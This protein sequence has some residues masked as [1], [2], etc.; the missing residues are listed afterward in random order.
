[1]LFADAASP[2]FSG[3]D[4]FL[5]TRGSF[6]LDF[7][8][9]AMFAVIPLLAVS[10][11]LVRYRRMYRVHK[12]MQV[13]LGVILLAAVTLFEVDMRIHGWR[14]RAAGSD[15]VVPAVVNWSLYVHL[16][17]AVSTAVL[18]VFVTVQALRKFPRPVRPSPYS[19]AHIFWARL[20]AIDM[21]LT[22]ITGWVFY[23]LAFVVERV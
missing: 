20:A 2:D 6:M 8:F 12:I 3:I 11:Y 15:G 13:T 1:M 4:G 23:Y 16:V 18:W 7:V 21:T 10:I 17:F 14:D 19:P 9:V 5:G 22:A